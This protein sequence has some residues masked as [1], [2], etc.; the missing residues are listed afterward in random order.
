MS[1]NVE[2]QIKKLRGSLGIRKI[3]KSNISDVVLGLQALHC[4]VA[5]RFRRDIRIFVFMGILAKHI[6][7]TTIS[8]KIYYGKAL[9]ERRL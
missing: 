1:E 7:V 9:Y 5:P 4:F 6:V 8:E 3:E 2:L